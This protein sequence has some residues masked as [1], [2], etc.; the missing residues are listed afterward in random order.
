LSAY[1]AMYALVNGGDTALW[2]FLDAYYETVFHG[3]AYPQPAEY[4]MPL[5]KET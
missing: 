5:R 2:A 3:A 4:K 1:D